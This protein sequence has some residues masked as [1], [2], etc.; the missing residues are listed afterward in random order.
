MSNSW[1]NVKAQDGKEFKAYASRPAKVPAAAVVVIQEIFGVNAWLRQVADWLASCG[2]LAVAPDLFFR[3]EPGVELTDKTQAEW[4]KAFKFYNEFDEAQGVKDLIATV[5]HVRKLSECN[6]HV[7]TLGFCLGGK[8][9]Y[10]MSTRS[11]ANANVG[12]YGVGIENNLDERVQ[13]PLLLHIAEADAHVPP[14]AQQAIKDKLLGNSNVVMQFYPGAGHAF[15]R[16]GSQ[17]YDEAAKKAA[18]QRSIEFLNKHLHAAA[19]G[20]RQV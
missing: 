17:H 5:E 4:D 14:E 20:A 7:G 9:A 2:F 3:M 11:S 1:I 18:E 16:T 8:L 6:G 10:L 13:Q 15:C 19:T 12:F